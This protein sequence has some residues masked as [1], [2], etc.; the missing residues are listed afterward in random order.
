MTRDRLKVTAASR[1]A[2]CSVSSD[3]CVNFAI[4][5][6][7]DASR[8]KIKYF[9][10]NDTEHL[11]EL[12]EQQA[13]ED[14]RSP[15]QAKTSRRFLIVE[16]IYMNTG[17]VCNIDKVYIRNFSASLDAIL[18]I[19]NRSAKGTSRVHW[20]CAINVFEMVYSSCAPES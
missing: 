20:I 5:K 12:L 11:E 8:S 2:I 17:T 16:G 9:R 13:A 6:G 14:R 10:H 19:R 4:Q 1:I 3:E 15:K 7:L 18:W